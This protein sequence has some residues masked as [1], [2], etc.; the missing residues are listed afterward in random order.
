MRKELYIIR[1]DFFV[2]EKEEFLEKQMLYPLVSELTIE[3]FLNAMEKVVID[4]YNNPNTHID[5]YEN[6]EP[7]NDNMVKYRFYHIRNTGESKD[8]V[9]HCEHKVY[10]SVIQKIYKE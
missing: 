8:I 3:P 6:D 2:V 7:I 1:T 10:I 5:F 9:F 4:E